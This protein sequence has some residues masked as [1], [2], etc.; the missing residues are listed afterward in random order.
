MPYFPGKVAFRWIGQC[1][2]IAERA[3]ELNEAELK[4]RSFAGL[5]ALAPPNAREKLLR[6]GVNDYAAVFARAI[7]RNA[8]F[9][10]PPQFDALAA[11]VIRNHHRSADLR[12]QA[13]MESEPRRVAAS[14]NIRFDLYASG[15]Y[16]KMLAAEWGGEQ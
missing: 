1:M 3:P 8:L 6:W 2:E 16:A 15:E 7:G 14:G 11:D 13:F 4:R 12:Y 5:L 9:A 10:E